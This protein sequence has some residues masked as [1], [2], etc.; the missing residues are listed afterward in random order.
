MRFSGVSRLRP[1][2]PQTIIACEAPPQLTTQGTSAAAP[3]AAERKTEGI[4]GELKH[5]QRIY[6]YLPEKQMK[7]VSERRGIDVRDVYTVASFYPHFHLKKPAKVNVKVCNDMSCHLRGSGQ[8]YD[9]LKQR[10]R[11]S[12]DV[13]F[14]L[15]E[16]SCFGRCDRAPAT[17]VVEG[18]QPAPHQRAER[19][20][21]DSRAQASGLH[22]TIF[23]SR[24]GTTMTLRG[25]A[26]FSWR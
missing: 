5:I 25:A 23:T 2:R 12:A 11:N 14:S 7:L 1:R 16:A 9:S 13:D 15:Q 17:A 8:L 18:M 3:Q 26:P 10:F 24:S 21:R 22:A 6:G 19:E 4:F 20:S